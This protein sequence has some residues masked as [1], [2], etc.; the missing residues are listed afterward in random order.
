MTK[1]DAT[2]SLD[3]LYSKPGHLIRRCQQIAVAIFLEETAG[4]G[5]TSVQ[6]AALTAI[7]HYPSIDATRLSQLVAFDRSTLGNVLERLEQKKLIRR[8]SGSQD[9]RI[10][11]IGL[12]PAGRSLLDSIEEA[13]ERA[14]RR[15]LEP[16]SPEE[17]GAFVK[18]LGRLVDINNPLSRAPAGVL[19]KP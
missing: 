3:D 16:L 18:M 1:S 13:V 5:I 17:Q 2:G 8:T 6:Y 15:I 12:T 14:Q 7:R 11:K 4:F 19:E 10:K 9:R